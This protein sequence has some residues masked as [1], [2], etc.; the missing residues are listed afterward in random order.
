MPP[1][2]PP[3]EVRP[4]I[5]LPVWPGCTV[6][7]LVGFEVPIPTK[8]LPLITKRSLVPRAEEEEILNLAPSESSIPIVHFSLAPEMVLNSTAASAPFLKI[9]RAWLGV[10]VP[11]PRLPVV[12]LNTRD[13][14]L[15]ELM[16]LPGLKYKSA[17]DTKI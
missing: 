15:G 11:I 14:A 6:N 13:K 8:P 1:D 16:L 2:Q 3:S 10:V 12:P 17:F 9:D 4:I 7:Q 5:A